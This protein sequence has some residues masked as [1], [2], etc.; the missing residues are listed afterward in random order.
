MSSLP[1]PG[2]LHRNTAW[3]P[4]L[5]VASCGH[6][7]ATGIK[8]QQ[9]LRS[10]MSKIHAK[11]PGNFMHRTARFSK[12]PRIRHQYKSTYKYA[13]YAKYKWQA[14]CRMGVLSQRLRKIATTLTSRALHKEVLNCFWLKTLNDA[15]TQYLNNRLTSQVHDLSPLFSSPIPV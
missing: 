7:R 14:T 2:S 15:Y 8:Y 13:A 5:P 4:Q 1:A 6:Q 3:C 9:Y 11:T 12:W 10:N